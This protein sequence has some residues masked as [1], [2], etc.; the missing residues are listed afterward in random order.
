MTVIYTQQKTR[1]D[2][3]SYQVDPF[4]AVTTFTPSSAFTSDLPAGSCVDA[5]GALVTNASTVC[6]VLS[7]GVKAGASSAVVFSTLVVLKQDALQAADAAGLAKAI[8]ILK[9]EEADHH[10]RLI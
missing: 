5:A 1:A 3:L 9:S 10:I 2:V 7:D 4:Y 6:H 8:T